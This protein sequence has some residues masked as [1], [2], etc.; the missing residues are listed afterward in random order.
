MRS[1][2]RW[3]DE[4]LRQAYADAQQSGDARKQLHASVAL[5]PVDPAQVEY[6]LP[7]LL[8]AQTPQEVLVIR[9][10]LQP[11]RAELT[12]R[13]WQG[14]EHPSGAGGRFRAACPWAAYAEEDPRWE[15]VNRAVA[16]ELVSQNAL[17]M[18][19]WA[20][21]LRPVRRYLLP[22][23]AGLL[24]EPGRGAGSCR[25]IAGICVGYAQDLPDA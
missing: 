24:Q 25:T 13:L 21:A 22:P 3:L 6:L 2:R 19:Q 23:L 12:E 4:P 7:R 11:H 20:E 8:T 5:L 9:Q 15:Q 18:G 16:G 14:L 10:A 1:Y 17:V